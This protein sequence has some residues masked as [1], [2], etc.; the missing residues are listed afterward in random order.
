MQNETEK[1][2]EFLNKVFGSKTRAAQTAVISLPSS[3]YYAV[4]TADEDH[5][6]TLHQ[7]QALWLFL[8]M[9]GS[10]A[11][12]WMEHPMMLGASVPYEPTDE[13]YDRL[14]SPDVSDYFSGY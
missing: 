2:V 9:K 10:P 12:Y 5:I 3:K 4:F 6:T 1:V 14:S 8:N 7:R 13:E 11:E